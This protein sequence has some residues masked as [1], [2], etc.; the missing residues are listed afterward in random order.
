MKKTINFCKMVA[1]GN[2]FVV[3]AEQLQAKNPELARKMCDRKY[4]V[5]ADGMLLVEKSS[6]ADIR[7]RIFNADGSEAEMCGNGARCAAFWQSVKH[8]TSNTKLKIET[9]AG[10]VESEI[11]GDNVRIKFTEPKDI[12]LDIPLKVNNRNLKVNFINTGV[13]HAIVFV[14]GLDKIDVHTIGRAI[15]YHQ[16]FQPNGT[17][18]DFVEIVNDD[19]I[20]VRTYE[21]GVEAET[22]ACGTGSTASAIFSSYGS[23]KSGN[24][25]IKVKT[26]GGEI[27]KVFF[28]KTNSKVSNIWLEGLVRI[29][30]KGGYYV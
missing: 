4:G 14:E 17:N 10:V 27:L 25:V 24:R 21:R 6:K 22:L 3:I 5:G 30:Y 12:R 15:R 19:F 29:V 7:M 1:A 18:V 13:P 26:R 23:E 11:N 9:K 2:D 20:K 16:K 8:K 28:S